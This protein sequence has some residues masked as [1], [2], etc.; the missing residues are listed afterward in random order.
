[1]A[2]F[3]PYHWYNTPNIHLC[4]V[5]DFETMCQ[6]KQLRIIARTVVDHHHQRHCNWLTWPNLFGEVAIY[7]IAR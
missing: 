4:T 6:Q 3:L 5:K 2:K 1:M 7:H